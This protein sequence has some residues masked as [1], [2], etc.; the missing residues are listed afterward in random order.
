M[1]RAGEG[2]QRARRFT[3]R[4]THGSF[5]V[6][7]ER[8]RDAGCSRTSF[9]FLGTVRLA[10]VGQ[11][12]LPRQQRPR[13]SLSARA[14]SLLQPIPSGSAVQRPVPAPAPDAAPSPQSYAAFSVLGAGVAPADSSES[15]GVTFNLLRLVL[16]APLDNEAYY[17]ALLLDRYGYEDANQFTWCGAF[18]GIKIRCSLELEIVKYHA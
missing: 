9:P 1:P 14:A 16:V 5:S 6:G 11:S 17:E 8:R 10:G 12:C 15:L 3:T 18:A 2:Q 4:S 13:C 7:A